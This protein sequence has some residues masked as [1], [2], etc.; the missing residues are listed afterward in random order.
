[1]TPL[2]RGSLPDQVA[3]LL[4]EGITAS[5]WSRE[6]P[7][8]AEL[9]REL[10]VSRV[11]LRRGIDQLAHS[12]WLAQGGRGRHHRILKR[13]R[14][15]TAAKGHIVRALSPFSLHS[16][17]SIQ[18]VMLDRVAERLGAAGCRM[19]YEYRPALFRLHA[20]DE[21]KRLSTLPDTGAWM[22]YFSTE[23]MQRWFAE[24]GISCLVFGKLYEGV[25]LPNIFSDGLATGRH[26]AG[27][28]YQRGHREL[29]YFIAKLTSLNDRLASEA[30]AKEAQRLGAHARIVTH[31]DDPSALS[32]E[33]DV[34]LAGRARPT[35]FFSTCPEHCLT[36]L[37][38]LI[39]GGLRVPHDASIISGWD[40]EFLH[41]AL[42]KFAC[43]RVNGAKMGS[44]AA[45]ILLDLIQHD[46]GKRHTVSML[47]EFVPGDTL[48][49]APRTAVPSDAFFRLP[50]SPAR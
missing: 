3:E 31:P 24:S 13:A 16:L 23:P 22:V 38:H 15:P 9:C 2:R 19:E 45:T 46:P 10:Q 29:V 28:F 17:G 48:G 26:A 49:P 12:G 42:P 18:H 8:E 34:L 7:S 4:R 27:L 35:A 44:K 43:Y 11:T 30:F 1:M 47:P 5:R 36:I 50:A 41:Y 40:D 33:L 21:L 6:L 14:A 25:N 37:C 39:E 20:P 32:R